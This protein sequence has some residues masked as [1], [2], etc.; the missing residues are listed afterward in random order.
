MNTMNI[1]GFTAEASLFGPNSHYGPEERT[2]SHTPL[3][4]IPQQFER[5]RLPEDEFI[6]DPSGPYHCFAQYLEQCSPCRPG[7]FPP[8]PKFR[9]PITTWGE[10]V[11]WCRWCYSP[12]IGHF[13]LCRPCFQRR[14]WPSLV[15]V[16]PRSPLV[17]GGLGG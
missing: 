1:P 8:D 10:S 4:V 12:G 16:T 15:P 2:H 9:S 7:V 5:P 11:Q 3:G 17:P 14:C 13:Q 6:G